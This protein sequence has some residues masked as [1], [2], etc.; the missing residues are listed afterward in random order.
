VRV[1]DDVLGSVFVSVWCF[2]LCLAWCSMLV[3][4]VFNVGMR[5]D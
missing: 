5:G 2:L 4:V 1:L 3:C